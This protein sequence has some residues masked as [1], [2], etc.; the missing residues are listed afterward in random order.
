MGE[1]LRAEGS[2][3]YSTLWE[4]F[5]KKIKDLGY[6]VENLGIHSLQAGS[7][8][9]AANAGVHVPD[10]LFKR[11]DLWRSENAKDSYME[12]TL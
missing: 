7:A 11:H 3:G 12:D 5:K 8:T 9:A 2:I 1:Y 6:P 4:L 10:R